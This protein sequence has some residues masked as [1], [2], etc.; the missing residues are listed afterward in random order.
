MNIINF[1]QNSDGENSSKRLIG[2]ASGFIVCYLAI[3]GGE[4]FLAIKDSKS[5]NDLVETVAIFSGTMLGIGFGEFLTKRKYD[6][7]ANTDAS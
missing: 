6:K 1:L 3:R 5:F 7:P 4:H 2:I